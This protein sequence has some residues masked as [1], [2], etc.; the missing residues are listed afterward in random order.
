MIRIKPSRGI[1]EK[2]LLGVYLDKRELEYLL[3]LEDG[4]V[5]NKSDVKR[6]E[7]LRKIKAIRYKYKFSKWL[8][9][10]KVPVL[11]RIGEDIVDEYRW[12]A[13]TNS[14]INSLFITEDILG[15]QFWKSFKSA[16]N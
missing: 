9:V 12:T 14:S 5:Q 15:N 10:T 6:W 16:S 2:M 13:E 8:K 11:T 7:N 1:M 3:N 4:I